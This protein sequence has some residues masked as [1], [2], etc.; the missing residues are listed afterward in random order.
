MVAKSDVVS[1]ISVRECV[2]RGRGGTD[3]VT[4]SLERGT[5]GISPCNGGCDG[6]VLRWSGLY[7]GRI[8]RV[9]RKFE[10]NSN[11]LPFKIKVI[12]AELDRM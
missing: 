1:G 9:R 12:Q 10:W 7:C 11:A 6:K 8:A 2:Y 5:R 4:S 3:E